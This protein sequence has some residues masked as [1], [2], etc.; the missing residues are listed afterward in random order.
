MLM[1]FDSAEDAGAC[2]AAI[3][4]SGIIPVAIEYMDRP[5]IKVCEAF[6]HAGYP[7]DVEALLIVE[8]EGSEAEIADL[9][10]RITA[11]AERFTPADDARVEVGSR[12]RRHLE[13]PQGRL[14]RDGPHLR[15]SLHGRRHPD[16]PAAGGARPRRRDLRRLRPR[17][18]PTSSTP[19]TATCT[20]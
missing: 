7:L 11:I 19:A 4:A 15:L 16:R 12:E 20:R 2:V 9:I 14:R 18:S 3:I 8:V 17:P 1:G 5:A 13:G 10:G 6:A